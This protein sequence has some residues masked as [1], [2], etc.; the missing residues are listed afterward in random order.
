[1]LEKCEL[2][3]IVT[4]TKSAISNIPSGY[5]VAP[6]LE[7]EKMMSIIV[8][9][10]D[11]KIIRSI[12]CKNTDLFCNLEKQ[13]YH[14]NIFIFDIRNNFTINGRKINEAKSLDDNKIKD[15]DIII[16]NICKKLWLT[17]T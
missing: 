5:V 1:M 13:I 8:T 4:V 6:L 14:N 11:K 7:G 17:M 3:D 12:I 2:N 9:S 10:P 15:N 16:L